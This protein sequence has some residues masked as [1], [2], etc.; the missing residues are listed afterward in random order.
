VTGTDYNAR[1][2]CLLGS[3]GAG[4]GNLTYSAA[5]H[6]FDNNV[7]IQ[8]TTST[9]PLQIKNT[10]MVSGNTQEIVFG[11]DGVT[12]QSASLRFNYNTTAASNTLGLGFWSNTNLLQISQEGQITSTLASQTDGF[13][14]FNANLASGTSQKLIFGKAGTTNQ[15]VV[16]DYNYNTTASSNKFGVGFWANENVMTVAQTGET[17]INTSSTNGLQVYNSAITSGGT[18]QS[19]NWGKAG[20]T[21]QAVQLDFNYNTTSSSNSLGLGFWGNNNLVNI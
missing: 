10:A 13:R 14:Q 18:P 12:N 15:A 5:S 19:L 8:P 7:Y 1:I 4:T 21:N 11:K 2:R 17:I 20:I 3:T 9:I 6:T 16:L